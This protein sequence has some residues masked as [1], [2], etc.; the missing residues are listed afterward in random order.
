MLGTSY[1]LFS[2]PTKLISQFTIHRIE[3]YKP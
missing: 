3:V 2:Y 1:S